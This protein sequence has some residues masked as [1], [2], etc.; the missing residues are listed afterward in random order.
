MHFIDTF[1]IAM[2]NWPWFCC[3]CFLFF[4]VTNQNRQ[5]SP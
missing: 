5:P 1:L 4:R 3:P 2:S